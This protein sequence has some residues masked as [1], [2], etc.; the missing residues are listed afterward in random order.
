M[1]KLIIKNLYYSRQAKIL[2]GTVTGLSM[3]SGLFCGYIYNKI[4][5][6][7]KSK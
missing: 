3:I 7:V 6:L 4:D 5:L 2:I 1:N